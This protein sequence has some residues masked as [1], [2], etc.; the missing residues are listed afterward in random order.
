MKSNELEQVARGRE[1]TCYISLMFIS[2]P[3]PRRLERSNS[4]NISMLQKIAVSDIQ[5][6][7]LQNLQQVN[8]SR[9]L[10]F[11]IAR[12]IFMESTKL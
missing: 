11:Y 6:C 12:V 10:N 1:A 9:K 5:Q 4:A 8:K 2:P 7:Y 3:R